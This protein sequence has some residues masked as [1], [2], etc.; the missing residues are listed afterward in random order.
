[1]PA[2][3]VTSRPR[4][5][6]TAPA[7]PGG[8]GVPPLPERANAHSHDPFAGEVAGRRA[9]AVHATGV[10]PICRCNGC[11]GRGPCDRSN[12]TSGARAMGTGGR[13]ATARSGHR[14]GRL[15]EQ[16]RS[17]GPSYSHALH[18]RPTLSPIPKLSRVSSRSSTARHRRRCGIATQLCRICSSVCRSMLPDGACVWM[19]D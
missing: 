3:S 5:M 12:K 9:S 2:R 14:R 8:V 19:Q 18:T 6:H 13:D 16:G 7:R 10:R 1:M 4:W 15:S 17:R 11:T